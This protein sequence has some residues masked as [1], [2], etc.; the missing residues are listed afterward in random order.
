M[1]ATSRPKCLE[2]TRTA[3]LHSLISD[4]TSPT[5]E[6]NVFWLYGVAG[7][8]KST[9]STTIA[10]HLHDL[11]QRGAFLFFDRNAPLQNGPNGVVR[12]LA[13][14][15]ALSNGVL[16]DAICDAIENDPQISA[17]PL[18]SQLK[19]LVLAPLLACAA[20]VTQPIVVVLDALDEC[21]DAQSRRALLHLLS[22]N[23]PQLPRVFRFLLTG[24]PE[25]DLNNILSSH[26]DI[27]SFPLNAAAWSSAADVMRYIQYEL[28]GLYHL[29]RG[30]DELPSGWP[31]ESRIALFGLRAGESFIWAATGIRYLYAAD[32]L[33]ERLDRLLSQ[34]A[35]SLADLYATALR[36][37]SN[38]DPTERSAEICRKILGAVVVGRTPLTDNTI[39]DILGLETAKS[40]RRILRKLGCLLQWS[41]GLPVRTLHASFSD[42]LTDARMCG[43]QPW[44]IDEAQHHLGFTIGCMRIMKRLLRFNICGLETSHLMNCD[45]RGLTDRIEEHIPLSLSYACCFWSEH[46]SHTKTPSCDVQSLILQFFQ[47]FFLYWLEVL[48]LTRQGHAALATMTAVESYSK[49]STPVNA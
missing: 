18:D 28:D 26:P 12:T 9:I 32:D 20:K 11:G 44:F 7:S 31:G 40:S 47:V 36:S 14:Q 19:A 33:D 27:K 39:D 29:R 1:D 30:S 41:E 21:G 4:L 17:R 34:Q 48:S 22:T 37:A 10:D 5:L 42:Y 2:G 8:G 15:L 3:I 43:D 13:Y 24:R 46:L 6:K 23:L 49:V 45:V 35:F 38:W 25:L 16:R